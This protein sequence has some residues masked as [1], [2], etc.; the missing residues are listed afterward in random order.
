[1]YYSRTAFE[2]PKNLISEVFMKEYDIDN[3]PDIL[4]TTEYVLYSLLDIERRILKSYYMDKLKR[5]EMEEL[6]GITMSRIH[7]IKNKALRKLR[8]P[9]RSKLLDGGIAA[10]II[11]KCKTLPIEVKLNTLIEELGLSVRS[12]N[13][14]KRY[15]GVSTA[16][17]ILDLIQNGELKK[18]RNLGNK[19]AE[20]IFYIM[21]KN[22]FEFGDKEL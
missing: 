8:H 19:C 13:C 16:G 22:K 20:E 4:A 7:D 18:I 21:K 15:G 14:L 1:M 5:S 9:S 12:Y 11:T 3:I 17:D 10:M 6:Y 2:Y